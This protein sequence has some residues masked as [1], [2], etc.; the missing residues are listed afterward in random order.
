MSRKILLVLYYLIISKLPKSSFPGGTFFNYLRTKC[1]KGIL[2]IG[3]N[4]RFQNNI[5]IGNGKNI[6]IGNYS[7]INEFVK[8]DNVVIG[9]YVMVARYV[10]FLGKT[11]N[12]STTAIPMILQGE[13]E[14]EQTIVEDDV[15]IGANAIIMPGIKIAKGSIIAAGAVLTK[16]TEPYSIMA[17]VPATLVRKRK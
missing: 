2:I 3:D 5:Y 16:D 8:L 6:T 4:C 15:W 7:H 9:N 17:G 1:L 12:F 13:S 10:T 11:H 14:S